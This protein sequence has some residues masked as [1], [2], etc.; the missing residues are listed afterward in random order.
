MKKMY[1]SALFASISAI[2]ISQSFFVPTDY[3]GAFAPA[4]TAMWTDNWTNWD[5]QN[6]TYGTATVTVS[7]SITNNTTWTSGNVYL[8]QGQIYVKNGATLTI[9]PGTVI[10]GD[11]SIPGSGLFVTQGS[12]LMAM[13]TEMS[14]I[15][16]TSNQAAGARGA[17]DW[18]G[19]ILLGRAANNQPSGVANIEGI[20]PNP[21][22]QFGG[23]ASPDD[24]DNSGT[25][26]YVRIEFGGYVYQTDKE[27]NGLTMGSV[28]RATTIHHIQTSFTN[29]D[30]YEWFGGT[31]NC[32][33]LVSYRDLDD[34]FDADF[35]F[36]GKIQF[37]LVVRDPNI[38]D[39]PSVSTSEGFESDNDASGSATTPKTSAIFS[40]ITMVGPYRGSTG[41]TIAAGYRR[42]ARLRRN[43]ELKIYN[44]LFM[45]FN[46]G[47][48]IDGTACETN[49]TNGTLKF[50]NNVVAG[51]AT[52]R[53]VE[54]NTGSTFNITGFFGANAND[55][56]IST[57]GILTTPYSYLAPD[58]RPAGGS[59][60]LSNFDFTDATLA[61]FVLTAPAVTAASSYC[62]G[63][64]ATAISATAG[65]GNTLNYYTTST[66][67]TAVTTAPV[68]STA[69]AGVYNYYVSQAN[70][71]G[72]ES[73][74]SQITI[75]VNALPSTPTINASGPT[76]FCTGGSVDLTSSSSTTYNWSSGATSQMIT[77]IASGTFSVTVADANGCEATSSDVTIN[78]SS[79]P[80]PTVQVTGSVDLCDGETVQLSSS[81]AD[82]YSWSNGA[83]TQAITV[84][85]SGT[86]FVTTTNTDACDGVGQSSSTV[87]TVTPQPA[88]NGTVSV[89]GSV[90]TF[91]NTSTNGTTYA[92]DFGDFT[93]SSAAAPTHAYAANGSYT[94]TLTAINGNCTDET[95]FTVNITV[96]LEELTA[97]N[98]AVVFPNPLNDKATLAIEL[99]TQSSLE[100]VVMNVNGQ[101]V[102]TIASADFEAGKHAFEI[103][104]T[105]LNQGLY[106]TVIRSNDKVE[107]IKFSVVK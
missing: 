10:L 39:N 29:D 4:P 42:G 99:S 80:L 74:R 51:V 64:T 71:E 91:T 35:G 21:D 77:V 20:A 103:N 15:V 98:S 25:L 62:V 37:G 18:G 30:A 28:G 54:R 26:T 101:L 46:R 84:S 9:Q 102:Q 19:I 33:H 5:P 32:H 43:T 72:T 92:W 52:G 7:T 47:L 45:D 67:G 22:T 107:T 48:H 36:S 82:S 89:T 79:A 81:T 63:E 58:Y 6:T 40:N 56:L 106:Y 73:P 75:T 12:K 93:S 17:G 1:M 27:I 96:G 3:R 105:N 8:L 61:P 55:S 85:S 60:L 34:N 49:A 97:L 2:A 31:V 50:E 66:G 41:N 53:V 68:P 83:S 11:K 24:N 13:G 87:V 44:S 38:A 100:I 104:A 86:Y 14:P 57:T 78:V 70:A 59:I 65:S 88:A 69:V 76:S 16:F 23:G 95:T 90:A 94:V